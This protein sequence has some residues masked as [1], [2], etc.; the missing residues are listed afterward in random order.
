LAIRA[1]DTLTASDYTTTLSS[2]GL[3]LPPSV[4]S[5][6]FG[7]T[8]VQTTAAFNFDPTGYATESWVTGQGYLT[9]APVTSV[10]GRTG[11]VTLANTDISGL[12]TMATATAADYSTTTAANGLYYPLSSNPAGYLTS[13]PVTSVAGRTGAVTLA[14]AD[15]SDAAPLASPTFTGT[16]SLPTGT[17]G[18]TQTAGNNTTALATTAFVQQEVPDF[19]TA[20]EARGF[21]STTASLNPRQMLWAML[22]QNVWQV[23]GS[24]M[25]ATNVG[26]I[27]YVQAGQLGRVTRPGTAGACSSRLR[28][29]GTSQVDQVVNYNNRANP[30]GFNFS[31]R[32]IHSGRSSIAGITQS[33]YN[34]AFYYGKAEAD[35]VGDLVRRGYGW[36]LVGGAGSRFLQLEVHN[37]TTLT[38]VTS[39]FA[40]TA[41]VGFDWDIESDGAGN[42]TLYVNGSSVATSTAGPTGASAVTAVVWQEEIQAT[43]ALTNPFSDFMNSRGKFAVLNP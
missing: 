26:T 24:A 12:G 39:S 35:G 28:F 42:V 33:Q 10:A 6:T 9:S 20:A 41:Q 4:G 11:A 31:L 5:I 14:V 22:S 38:S 1:F 34:A 23:I 25:T 19:A 37:G 16:P 13:A 17:I 7:D 8:T 27:T 3:T 29:F 36:K 30:A 15:V 32:S 43:S 2:T 18:V 21:T 40:V